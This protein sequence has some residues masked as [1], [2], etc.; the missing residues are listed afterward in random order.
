M[1]GSQTKHRLLI[2]INMH[3]IKNIAQSVT[4]RGTKGVQGGTEPGR[5]SREGKNFVGVRKKQMR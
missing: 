2:I 1:D 3:K 4:G 5:G